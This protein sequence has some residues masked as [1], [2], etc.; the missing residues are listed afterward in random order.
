MVRGEVQGVR[1]AA[2]YVS[3][4]GR[5][6]NAKCW[7]LLAVYLKHGRQEWKSEN[8]GCNFVKHRRE[9]LHA[10]RVTGG[11]LNVSDMEGEMQGMEGAVYVRA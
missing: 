9:E 2:I 10:K 5:R 1:R 11:N 3:I 8:G 4:A 6:V 7:R